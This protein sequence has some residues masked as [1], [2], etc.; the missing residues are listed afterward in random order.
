MD[1]HKTAVIIGIV[2]MGFV[3]FSVGNAASPY[4]KVEIRDNPEKT[5]INQCKLYDSSRAWHMREYNKA[6]D[7][8]HELKC[9]EL[10][11][12]HFK[13]KQ[14]QDEVLD[15][16]TP[17]TKGKA[18]FNEEDNCKIG[19][20]S[21]TGKYI[22]NKY[23]SLVGKSTDDRLRVKNVQIGLGI[24]MVALFILVFI[25][26]GSSYEEIVKEEKPTLIVKK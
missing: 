21:S 2:C 11:Y 6:S 14:V 3:V 4:G 24:M 23:K 16:P 8:M 26:F 17:P 25:Y 18:I 19:E 12:R 15:E 1:K 9:E 7:R 20:Q 10:G 13:I 22:E 5:Q